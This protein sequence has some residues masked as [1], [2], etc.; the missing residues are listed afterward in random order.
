MYSLLVFLDQR[1]FVIG[2]GLN[3][4]VASGGHMTS[5]HSKNPGADTCAG[6][7]GW[8]G[9]NESLIKTHHHHQ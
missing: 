3:C 8:G 7:G 5:S 1:T 2:A 6:C 4:M 9:L